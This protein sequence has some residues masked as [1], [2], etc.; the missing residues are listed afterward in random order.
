MLIVLIISFIS[1]FAKLSSKS[2]KRVFRRLFTRRLFHALQEIMME[3]L[4]HRKLFKVNLLL[5]LMHTAFALLA[6]AVMYPIE[7]LAS[8]VCFVV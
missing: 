6:P 7:G 2:R 1:G 8:A 3:S 5:G 4:L